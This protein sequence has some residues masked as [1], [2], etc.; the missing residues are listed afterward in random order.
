MF[1]PNR[2]RIFLLAIVCLLIANTITVSAQVNTAKPWTYWWWMGGAVNEKDIQHSLRE[3]KRIGIGGVHIIPIYGVKGYEAEFKPF[4]SDKWMKELAYTLSEAKKLGIGVDLST[5]SGWPFGG[6]NVSEAQSAKKWVLKDGAFTSASTQQKVKRAGPG[7]TGYVAD[8]F[9]KNLMQQYLVRFDSAFAKQNV[10][11]LRSMYSDSYEV[12]GA[13]WTNNFLQEFKKRRGYDF[14]EVSK[15]F[16]DTTNN[17]Q[18]CLVKMDYQ[19][20]LSE[21]L[22]ES[23]QSWAVWSKQHHF[24]TR[25]QAHGSPGNLLDLYGLATIPETESFGSSNFTIPLLRVE[26]GYEPKTFGRPNPLTMKFASSEA[27]VSGKQLISSETCTWLANHFKVSLSQAK[28]QIDELFTAGINHVFF[29][30]TT[31]SPQAEK[32]PGWLFYAS[33]NWGPSAHF[34]N[35]L[36]LLTKYIYNCQSILQNS[37]PDNDML[38]YFPV[39]DIWADRNSGGYGI[40]QLD[41]HHSEAWFGALPF[42]KLSKELLQKGFSFDYIS[43]RQL[44]EVKV[45]QGKIQTAGANYKVIVVPHTTYL[46]KAT[47]ERLMALGK[48]GATIIFDQ[49]LP[50]FP[51]GY[52][53]FKENSAAFEKDKAVIAAD[54]THF[55]VTSDIVAELKHH[56]VSQ[57]TIANEGLTF[58]RKKQAGKVVYFIANVSD[59]FTGGWVNFATAGNMVG[60]DALNNKK[61]GMATRKSNGKTQ[62]YLSLLPGQSCFV[63]QGAGTVPVESLPKAYNAYPVNTTWQLQF[64]GGRPGYHKTFKLD[65]LQSWTALSDTAAFY[66]GTAKYTGTVNVP[67]GVSAKKDLMI[68]LGTVNESAVVKI[69]G[70]TVGTAWAIP[71]RLKI[72]AGVLLAGKNTLEITVTNLSSNYMKVYDKQHPEW[73][74]FYDANIVDITYTPFDTSKWPVM[75]SGLS[76]NNVRILY[77]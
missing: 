69:N 18:T 39:Q 30:G 6:P 61:F 75:P 40:H 1:I 64:L 27:G 17:Q 55:P 35:E 73:K 3:F 14:Q 68:D 56:G 38:I 48:Q 34:Y 24:I 4:L 70:K 15:I 2:T 16:L 71:F 42:G 20:T 25:Y 13:N 74:K 26:P 66:T 44:D 57:E 47:L 21:L 7:G 43:D 62:Y 65:T 19:Q 72:P 31:Y 33:T 46:P 10:A 29:H 59:K 22:Y 60:Y 36:P 51:M 54:K 63:M 12:F 32:Y 9:D 37:K 58:I 11:G 23:Y 8:P 53:N 28:P 52:A 45:S 49:S 77:R 41:V 76:T 67:A 50:Q 5:G